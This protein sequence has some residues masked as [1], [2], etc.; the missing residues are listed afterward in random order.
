MPVATGDPDF[1]ESVKDAAVPAPTGPRGHYLTRSQSSG[2]SGVYQSVAAAPKLRKKGS[3]IAADNTEPQY[4]SHAPSPLRSEYDAKDGESVDIIS[5]V[6]L[7][8]HRQLSPITESPF[9]IDYRNSPIHGDTASIH[10]SAYKLFALN[11]ARAP[12]TNAINSSLG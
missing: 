7:A 2:A 11:H 5:G 8:N 4:T 9:S 10:S 3:S 6:R 12:F 1:W